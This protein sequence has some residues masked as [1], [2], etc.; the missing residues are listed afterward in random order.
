MT[1][2]RCRHLSELFEQGIADLL[3]RV[4]PER[5]FI[6]YREKNQANAPF[7]TPYV[8]HGFALAN[9]FTTEDLSIEVVRKAL[10]NGEA[11]LVVDALNAPGLN[12]RSSVMIAGLRSVLTVPLRH[13][14]GLTVGLIYADSRAK[15]GAFTLQHL[16][17][18]KKLGA[19]LIVALPSVEKR[20][21]DSEPLPRSEEEFDVVKASA[22]EL[23]KV[24]RSREAV[25]LLQ[26]WSSGR[27]TSPE[28]GMAHGVRGRILDQAGDLDDALEAFSYSVW[29]LA[30]HA[31][32]PDENTSLMM[33]N[34]AGV[35][36][37]R[38]NLERAIGLLKASYEQWQRLKLPNKKQFAGLAATSYNLGTLLQQMGKVREAIP[39]M[40]DALDASIEAFGEQHERVHQIAASLESLK[41]E[42]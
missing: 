39:W 21:R 22:L 24:D 8:A 7:P 29:I 33:N 42:C 19:L 9:L 25:E 4:Q 38:G 10:S 6:A 36:V 15:S 13:P 23:A 18:V 30:S 16:E 41:Q 26:V 2:E 3:A 17:E 20:Q 40:T 5:A 1:F 11:G 12:T 32:G 34:L 14:S 28:L 35:Q 27:A 37:K 31:K